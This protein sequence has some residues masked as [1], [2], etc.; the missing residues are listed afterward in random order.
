MTDAGGVFVALTNCRD[1]ER[2]EEFLTWYAEVQ[3]RKCPRRGR[4]GG[5]DAV[6][7]YRT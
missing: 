4:R 6:P 2:V 1:E 5:R 3:F 7:K